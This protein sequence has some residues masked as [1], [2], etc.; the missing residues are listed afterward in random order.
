[1]VSENNINFKNKKEMRERFINL[2]IQFLFPS[3]K[4]ISKL[5]K[6]NENIFKDY[7]AG[8]ELEDISR[9]YSLSVTRINQILEDQKKFFEKELDGFEFFLNLCEH[10]KPYEL[11]KFI[12]NLEIEKALRDF[13]ESSGR[14]PLSCIWNKRKE[15]E[16]GKLL[17]TKIDKTSFSVRTINSL[18]VAEIYTLG[19]LI[20]WS[21][22]TKTQSQYELESQLLK[23]RNFGEQSLYEVRRFLHE[24]NV[25]EYGFLKT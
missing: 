7:L 22:D 11:A 3:N 1:M 15:K 12:E 5:K 4:K 24:N 17:S 20:S 16:F 14:T 18:K 23:I 9:K 8:T 13:K 2:S 21:I 10:R 25:Q 6:R 19:D